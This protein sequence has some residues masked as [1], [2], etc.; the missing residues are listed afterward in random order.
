MNCCLIQY[1]SLPL[2]PEANL[3]GRLKGR[4]DIFD[5][6]LPGIETTVEAIRSQTL[7][8]NFNINIVGPLEDGDDVGKSLFVEKEDVTSPSRG[9]SRSST[10]QPQ[11]MQGLVQIGLVSGP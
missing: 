2:S 5:R 6:H 3:T 9:I 11:L 8:H 1:N 4:E 10:L 7:V